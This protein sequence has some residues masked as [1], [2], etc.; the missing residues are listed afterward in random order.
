MKLLDGIYAFY[1]VNANLPTMDIME[2]RIEKQVE[3]EK[4]VPGHQWLKLLPNM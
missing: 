1:K 2:I 4:K 3:F